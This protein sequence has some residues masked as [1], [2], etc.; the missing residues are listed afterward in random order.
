MRIERIDDKTVKCYLSNEELE[1]YDITYKDF[2]LRS[3]KARE[4]IEDII[5]QAEA[6][7]GYRP[8]KFAFDLQIMM[9][10]EQG[11]ILTFS[12]KDMEDMN[13]GKELMECLKQVKDILEKKHGKKEAA[14][15]EQEKED[16][17]LPLQSEH[18]EAHE[19]KTEQN[20]K[21]ATVALFSF[22][23]LRDVC[24]YAKM[25]PV[26]LE[27]ISALYELQGQYYLYL[28]KGEVPYRRYSRAC[29]QAMEFGALYTADEQRIEY[30]REHADCLIGE[31]ALQK[32]HAGNT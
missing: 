8:P 23:H 2:I 21:G 7:V 20:S 32:L 28:E 11:M 4:V 22:G 9:M 13:P 29:I 26:E 15:L 18:K 27:V 1:E 5:E 19:Q 3:D 14:K 24:Q 17:V 6:E 25:L 10:P 12:E 31:H 30:I 16:D